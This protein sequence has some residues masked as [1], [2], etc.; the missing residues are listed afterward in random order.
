MSRKQTQRALSGI[1]A[2]AAATLAGCAAMVSEEGLEADAEKAFR[3][4]KQQIPLVQDPDIID[5]PIDSNDDAIRS[6]RV[7][8][9]KLIVIQF[10]VCHGC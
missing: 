10:L 7:V 4:M 8:L 5:Y 1:G 9:K 2:L 6:I 3:Q